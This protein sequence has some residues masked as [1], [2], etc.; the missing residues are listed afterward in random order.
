MNHRRYDY[1]EPVHNEY[2][3]GRFFI[4]LLLFGMFYVAGYVMG[5]TT[6]N[7]NPQPGACYTPDKM[8]W[9]IDI[10]PKGR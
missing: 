7:P 3:G 4:R 9:E 10:Q 6:P 8:P 2:G 5:Y 1:L